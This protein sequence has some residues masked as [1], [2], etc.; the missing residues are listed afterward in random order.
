MDIAK[1]AELIEL[2]VKNNL[3]EIE[4]EEE[5]TKLR[6]R[7]DFPPQPTLV[8]APPPSSSGHFVEVKDKEPSL[9]ASPKFT[10]IRSPMVGIFYRSPSPNAQPYVEVGQEVTEDTVVCIIE[11]MKVMNEIKAEV[12]GIITEVL[13][14][15]GKPVDFNKPLFKVKLL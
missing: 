9:L 15:N 13:A 3:S 4:I 2:M 12:H 6:L 8:S 10:E 1:I 11:A 5:N 14:E 7:K